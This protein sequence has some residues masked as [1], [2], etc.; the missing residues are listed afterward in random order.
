MH[1]RVRQIAAASTAAL[2][3]TL[4]GGAVHGMT[5]VDSRL[6]ALARPP[7][8]QNRMLIDHRGGECPFEERER[9]R[10]TGPEEQDPVQRTG[11]EV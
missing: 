5:T 10:H 9:G 7:A 1:A 2:G 8:T 11:P 4:L 3:F 6:Q